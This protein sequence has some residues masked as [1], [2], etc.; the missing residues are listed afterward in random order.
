MSSP[1]RFHVFAATTVIAVVVLRLLSP[2]QWPPRLVIFSVAPVGPV[3]FA[4]LCTWIGRQVR[5]FVVL[6]CAIGLGLI[7]CEYGYSATPRFLRSLPDTPVRAIFWL[8]LYPCMY[9][10]LLRIRRRPRQ[11]HAFCP[12]CEYD[13]TGNVSGIC[14]E[15]GS[16]VET[17]ACEID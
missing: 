16:P 6:P 8:V 2:I 15:C 4:A 9:V 5:S 14:P 1:S 13:L 12:T 7:L 10:A 3:L 11:R 17:E